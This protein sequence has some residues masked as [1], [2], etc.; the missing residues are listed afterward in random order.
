MLIVKRYQKLIC[1]W[2]NDT[3][4]PWAKWFFVLTFIIFWFHK[5]LCQKTCKFKVI[6]QILFLV[7]QCPH[8]EMW[9]LINWLD[10]NKC[11]NCQMMLEI[12][13]LMGKWYFFLPSWFAP[14][15]RWYHIPIA[16]LI[17]GLKFHNIVISQVFCF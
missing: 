7:Y 3:I 13:L 11:L 1:P 10:W 8:S 17:F 6:T 2:G 4:S 9:P 5:F 14:W 16:K 12:I 15:G